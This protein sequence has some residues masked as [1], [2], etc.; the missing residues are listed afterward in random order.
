[1]N[2]PGLAGAIPH[3]LIYGRDGRLITAI[4][5]WRSLD[6]MTQKLDKALAK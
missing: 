5:G 3:Y 1:M 6:G 2:I 4:A